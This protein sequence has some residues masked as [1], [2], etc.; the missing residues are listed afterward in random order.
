M[1]FLTQWASLLGF[2]KFFLNIRR[3]VQKLKPDIIHANV[4]KSHITLF[5]LMRLGYHGKGVIHMRDIFTRP[6]ISYF[7]Y[8]IISPR[9]RLEAIAISGAVKK[10]L[11]RPLRHTATVIYN[12]VHILS[13]F[14]EKTPPPPVRFLYLGRIVPWKGCH[15]LIKTFHLLKKHIAAESAILNLVGATSYWNQDY[16]KELIQSIAQ[17][18]LKDYVSISGFTNDPYSTLK[19]HHVLCMMSE[20]EPFGRVAAEAMSAG[21]PVISFSSGGISEVVQ[22]NVTGFLI[23]D[24]EFKEYQKAMQSFIDNPHLITSMGSNGH[25][26][27]SSHFNHSL[28]TEKIVNF[29]VQ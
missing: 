28:Q 20:Q 27:A 18:N 11:P 29:L 24:S 5:L 15:L 8:N 9:S 1:S 22:H 3:L 21:L 10:A 16:R 25:Q 12:G 4:P 19:S 14:L 17:Y 26:R 13:D 2:I 23:E 7:L 6:S